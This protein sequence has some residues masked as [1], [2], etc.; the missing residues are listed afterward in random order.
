[1]YSGALR[2]FV[3]QALAGKPITVYEDGQQK[4][5]FVNV[6]DVVAANLMALRHPA[7]AYEIFNVGGGKPY[8][9]LGFAKAVKKLAGSDSPIVIGGFRRTDTRHAVSA[10]K[11]LQ[12][13]GW[14]PRYG[15]EKSIGDYLEWYRE[16]FLGRSVRRARA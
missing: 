2:I 1:L 13:L 3:T 9:V 10:T 8:S 16:N 4:R 11:K 15:I 7:A 12:R 14:R 6:A 5:D